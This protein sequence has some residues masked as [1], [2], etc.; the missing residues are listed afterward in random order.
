MVTKAV[1]QVLGKV[2][3]DAIKGIIQRAR[4]L[5]QAVAECMNLLAAPKT[6]FAYRYLARNMFVL[7]PSVIF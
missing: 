5:F 2:E 3:N 7:A 1:G 4:Q 6:S